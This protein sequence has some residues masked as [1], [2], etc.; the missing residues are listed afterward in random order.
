M[1]EWFGPLQGKLSGVVLI[2]WGS[3]GPRAEHTEEAAVAKTHPF[4]GGSIDY[5]DSF[6]GLQRELGS[7]GVACMVH[8]FTSR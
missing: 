1:D 3:A 5:G 4:L 7:R 6:V 2:I 8:G